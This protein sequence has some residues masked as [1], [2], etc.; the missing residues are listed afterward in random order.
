VRSLV[1][2][3]QR[4]FHSK[5]REQLSA[6]PFSL[7]R[8]GPRALHRTLEQHV[9]PMAGNT[10]THCS[11]IRPFSIFGDDVPRGAETHLRARIHRGSRLAT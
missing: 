11:G 8:S 7:Q 10:S 4:L 2:V 1:V 9:S 5:D 3:F 6:E